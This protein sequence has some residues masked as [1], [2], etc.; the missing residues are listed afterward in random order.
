[1]GRFILG[2]SSNLVREPYRDLPT[3]DWGPHSTII[4]GLLSLV[5]VSKCHNMV[6]WKYHDS[7]FERVS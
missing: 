4:G 1:M 7:G 6:Q 5:V 3:L 2:G